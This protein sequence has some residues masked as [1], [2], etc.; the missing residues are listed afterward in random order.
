MKRNKLIIGSAGLVAAAAIFAVSPWSFNGSK[1]DYAK[2]D[3]PSMEAKSAEDAQK[4]L[5]ARYIDQETGQPISSEKLALI[6]KQV[7]K[8][9]HSKAISFTEQ[10]PDNIGGRTRAIQIDRADR[11]RVWA[12]GVSEVCLRQRIVLMFGHVWIPM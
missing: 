4:W 2:K 10:G 12:G 5:Q 11:N 9:A 1:G 3:L 6:R 7:Q 8:S